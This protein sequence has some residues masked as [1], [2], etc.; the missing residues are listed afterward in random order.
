[1]KRLSLRLAVLAGLLAATS[2]HADTRCAC[3]YDD[4][5]G[6]CS[7]TIERQ[8]GWIRITSNTGQCSR[9]DWY[10]NGDPQTTIVQ[11]GAESVE[12]L[13]YPASS[14]LA[15]EGCKVCK[16]SMFGHSADPEGNGL[17]DQSD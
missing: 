2:V 6:D 8:G 17:V 14:N 7:A 4:W 1:M 13:N 9:V 10:I 5:L 11:D 16:D 12:L 15:I 3:G